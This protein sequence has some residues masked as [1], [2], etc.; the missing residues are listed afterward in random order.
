MLFSKISMGS[1]N[2]GGSLGDQDVGNADPVALM[3]Q[4][5]YLAVRK[6]N[7]TDQLS[8]LFVA[9]PNKE[10][11]MT[12]MKNYIETSVIP[13]I[14]LADDNFTAE[15]CKEFCEVFCKGLSDRAEELLQSLLSSIPY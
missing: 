8:E 2:F 9:V 1:Q 6:R 12:I 10:V 14:S 15:R 11:G 7:V 13:S 4:A 5:G 3:L